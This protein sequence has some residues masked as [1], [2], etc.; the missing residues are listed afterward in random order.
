MPDSPNCL[1]L[2]DTALEL[3]D[4]ITRLAD[5]PTREFFL[6]IGPPPRG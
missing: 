1:I 4:E 3:A 6:E 2:S 5:F